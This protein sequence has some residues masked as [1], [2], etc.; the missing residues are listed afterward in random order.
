MYL[1]HHYYEYSGETDDPRFGEALLQLA[2]AIEETPSA[3]ASLLQPHLE[4]IGLSISRAEHIFEI[5]KL[6]ATV[7][8][9]ARSC[10]TDIVQAIVRHEAYTALYWLLETP[11][12]RTP[13]ILDLLL[14]TQQDKVEHTGRTPTALYESA[15][16]IATIDALLCGKLDA[17]Q[18]LLKRRN[19]VTK[20]STTDGA[21]DLAFI[22]LDCLLVHGGPMIDGLDAVL[23]RQALAHGADLRTPCK[24]KSSEYPFLQKEYPTL[25]HAVCD[26]HEA[27][28]LE[29]AIHL[30]LDFGADWTGLD[31]A[32]LT[33]SVF[34]RSHPRWKSWQKREKLQ[35]LAAQSGQ[36]SELPAL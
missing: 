11:E 15:V 20:F 8:V 29:R 31:T 33:G 1:R 28:A 16:E 10:A 23:L 24:R 2:V 21:G 18:H 30:L 34:I 35:T 7:L 36:E 12:A 4:S 9:H 26:S 19:D 13:D 22:V 6:W 25:L 5:G 14:Q 27:P 32:N 17:W 3:A